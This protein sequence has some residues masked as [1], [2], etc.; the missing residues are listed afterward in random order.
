MSPSPPDIGRV[1]DDAADD[2]ARWSPLLWDPMGA[3]TVR[4]LAPAPGDRVLDVCCGRGSS[5]LPAAEA[6]GP[7]GAVDA[8][9]LSARLVAQGRA[10]AEAQGLEHLRFARADATTWTDVDR[11]DLVL[12]VYGVF[13][14]P[15]MEA[16]VDHLVGLVRPG[17]RFAMTTWAQGAILDFL[18]PFFEALREERPNVKPPDPATEPSMRVNT[19]ER[20]DAWLTARG[21]EDVRSTEIPF[22]V[23]ID[24]DL[25]WAFITGAGARKSLAGLDDDAV[26]RVRVG[27]L[28]RL[29]ARDVTAIDLRSLVSVGTR[30]G[31]GYARSLCGSPRDG[32]DPTK[33]RS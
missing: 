14:L 32:V 15:D 12:S 8:I 6:V 1:F 20:V 17:G 21:L 26:S 11:Y 24:D 9:D 28:E 30:L 3:T 7:T 23:D 4:E 18:G 27:L 13:F 2:F 5:A 33:N 10:V 29:H 25:A 31:G 16:G 22:T 19:S